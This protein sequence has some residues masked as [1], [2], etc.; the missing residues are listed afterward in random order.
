MFTAF[1]EQGASLVLDNDRIA[2]IIGKSIESGGRAIV[3]GAIK[4]IFCCSYY[5]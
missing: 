3:D 1:M 5:W 2:G 4:C